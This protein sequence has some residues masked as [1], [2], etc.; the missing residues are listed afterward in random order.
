[1]GD[2]ALGR[3]D[4]ERARAYYEAARGARSSG[5][6]GA[7]GARLRRP[8]GGDA[9][10]AA[11]KVPAG[12]GPGGYA[13]AYIGL[14]QAYRRMGRN[15]DALTAFQRYLE[16]LPGGPRAGVAQRNIDELR[17]QGAGGG[18]PSEPPPPRDDPPP[19]PPTPEGTLPPPRDMDR[20][21]PEDVPAVESD[22][23][24]Q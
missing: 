18:G 8:R 13:E 7:H 9:A 20:P 10:G 6:G 21:P 23:D 1:Q 5:S 4:L 12:R 24:L 3:N 11:A 15:S 2:A 16:R 14:G 19:A 17:A 22:P